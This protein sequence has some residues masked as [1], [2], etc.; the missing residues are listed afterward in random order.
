MKKKKHKILE[1]DSEKIASIEI[2]FLVFHEAKFESLDCIVTAF[3]PLMEISVPGVT[4]TQRRNK[5]IDENTNLKPPFSYSRTAKH[6][7][8]K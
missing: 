4:N 2:P 1:I 8:N 7:N 5:K 6:E 3:H